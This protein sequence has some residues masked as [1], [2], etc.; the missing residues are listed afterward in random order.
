MNVVLTALQE[1]ISQLDDGARLPTVRELMKTFR[2]SQATVQDALTRLREAGLL[3]SQVGRGTYVTKSQEERRIVR[4]PDEHLDSLLILANASLNERCV[5]VQN[6]IVD[7]MS[8]SGSKVVQISYH[9]TSHLLD[10]LSSIPD[11]DAVVLQSHYE[12]IPIRLLHLLQDKARALVV[13]GH[14]VSGVDLDRVG[15]D[16]EEALDMALDHLHELGHRSIALASLDT[17]AQPI[18]SVRRAFERIGRR[19]PDNARH[20]GPITLRGVL[21]PTQSVELA[22]KGALEGLLDEDHRLPFTAM[23]TLGISDALG[24][25]RCLDELG[26]SYPDKL[27]VF[28]LGHHDVPTEHFGSMSMAGSSY[29]EGA[30]QLVKTIHR[31]LNSPELPPQI[32]YLGCSQVIRSSTTSPE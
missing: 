3:T 7:E 20:F 10:M 26:I 24:I 31:R 12:N 13:D 21:H 1:Q 25:G 9:N 8:R 17:M 27:S 5:L 30:Q 4:P 6:Y 16:W 29:L 23:I 18:L 14:S 22:L 32:I 19:A 11:F 15:T 2:V 28:I